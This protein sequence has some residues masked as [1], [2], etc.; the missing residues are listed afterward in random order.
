M[1]INE[2]LVHFVGELNTQYKDA[3]R[4]LTETQLHF[5][6]DKNSCHIAFHSWHFVRTEDNIINF[7]CQDRKMP[8]WV[9]QGLPDKWGLPR[10]PQGTGMS[11]DEAR[12]L[13]LPSLE[14]FLGYLRDVS[15][16]IRPYLASATSEDLDSITEVRP[17]GMKPKLHHI[18][19]TVIA[20]GNR[21]LGQI[22]ALRTLEGLSGDNM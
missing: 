5:L 19:Q 8:V 12:A 21:H 6:P 11:M 10:V 4:D 16:D 13:R 22:M 9:R 2:Y 18:L 15:S 17:H 1:N 20:H 14:A 3:L 7:V